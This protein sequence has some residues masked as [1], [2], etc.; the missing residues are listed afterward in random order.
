MWISCTSWWE[1]PTMKPR[2]NAYAQR[3]VYIPS[4]QQT[5]FMYYVIYIYIYI[6]V[7]L[8]YIHKYI[9][10]FV[11]LINWSIYIWQAFEKDLFKVLRDNLG[12]EK[13]NTLLSEKV[14]PVAGDI[15]MDHLGMKDS[16]LRERMQKEIDIVVNVAATTNFDE[17]Y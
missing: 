13:L 11:H 5:L 1:H 9:I 7:L 4:Y 15:A 16:N 2:R 17:R 10:R 8:K 12:D 14:V 6:F 3:F